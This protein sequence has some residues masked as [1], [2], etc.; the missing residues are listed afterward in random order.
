[1]EEENKMD[2]IYKYLQSEGGHF[3]VEQE[4]YGGS[5]RAIVCH[6]SACNFIFDNLEETI[7]KVLRCKIFSGTMRYSQAL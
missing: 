2:N 7:L 6:R 1:M 3:A 5:Y 4:R